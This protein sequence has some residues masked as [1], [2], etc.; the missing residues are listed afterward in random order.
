MTYGPGESLAIGFEVPIK[1][2]PP[3]ERCQR[4]AILMRSRAEWRGARILT[5]RSACYE[6]P[7]SRNVEIDLSPV[8]ARQA[9]RRAGEDGQNSPSA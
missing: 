2:T 8:S 9:E 5:S 6:M 3:L 1:R 4:E 7:G